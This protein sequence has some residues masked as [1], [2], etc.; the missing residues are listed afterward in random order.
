MEQVRG[1]Y[2]LVVGNQAECDIQDHDPSRWNE[3]LL[4]HG[5]YKGLNES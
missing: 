1:R 2:I 4:L 3:A 5:G